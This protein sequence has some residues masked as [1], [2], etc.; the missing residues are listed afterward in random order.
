MREVVMEA[1]PNKLVLVVLRAGEI[2]NMT[3]CHVE[4]KL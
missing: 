2:M 4:V 1:E 3:N